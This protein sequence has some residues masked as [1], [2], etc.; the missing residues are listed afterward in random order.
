MLDKSRGL[1][2]GP[3]LVTN[4]TFNTDT[5]GW[6][7]GFNSVNGV[8]SASGGVA[9]YTVGASDG[10]FPRMVQALSGLTVG[11]FYRVS[12]QEVGGGT[13]AGDR[14]CAWTSSADGTGGTLNQ[15]TVTGWTD[16]TKTYYLPATATT[17]YF[18]VALAFAVAGAT[19]SIDNISVRELPGNHATQ[20][21][22]AARPI[23][24]IDAGGRPYLEFDGT[25]DFMITGA[26]FTL[27]QVHSVWAGA[28]LPARAA[29]SSSSLFCLS[30]SANG[31]NKRAELAA[32]NTGSGYRIRTVYPSIDTFSTGLAL[33][34]PS[35][36]V[37]GQHRYSG[38]QVVQRN[39]GAGT[40]NTI[41]TTSADFTEPNF[42][43][44]GRHGITTQY[45][46]GGLYGL[47]V[48][49]AAPMDA[50]IANA[51]RWIA[52]KTGVVLP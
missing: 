34:V 6:T 17:M 42:L 11:R 24:R 41:T 14:L 13:G 3:E 48:R 38:T 44:V 1:A 15:V 52:R 2:L 43:L 32:Y 36:V 46:V 7:R 50:Q 9:T 18:A 37:L 5:T 23:Y 21:T 4:G 31:D 45:L 8:F 25:D 12:F 27:G 51:E 40:S 10:A 28:N 20:A 33:T 47:V 30:G 26:A 29:G 16:E 49:G 39:A 22:L 19:M 35:A